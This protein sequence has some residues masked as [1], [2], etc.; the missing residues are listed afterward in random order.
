VVERLHR[1]QTF[2]F[3]PFKM[4]NLNRS[5][6]MSWTSCHLK[7]CPVKLISPVTLVK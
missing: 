6:K 1:S 4:P 3:N 7:A 5:Q 2:A